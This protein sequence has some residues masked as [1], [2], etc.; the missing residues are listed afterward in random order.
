V[1]GNALLASNPLTNATEVDVWSMGVILFCLLTGTLPFD[2]DD[3][4]IMKNKVIRGEYE[5][6]EWLSQGL[7]LVFLCVLNRE[8]I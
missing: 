5:D 6:P 2:D 4:A 3:E 8:L 7:I 1:S